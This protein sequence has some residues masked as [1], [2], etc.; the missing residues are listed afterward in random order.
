MKSK[1]LFV[2]FLTF[3]IFSC[4]N[5]D[6]AKPAEQ[7][8]LLSSVTSDGENYVIGYH[9]DKKV[10]LIEL[11]DDVAEFTYTD[12]KISSISKRNLQ[13]NE[14]LITTFEHDANGKIS[15]FTYDDLTVEVAYNGVSNSYTYTILPKTLTFELTTNGEVEKVILYDE[16]ADETFSCG[17]TFDNANKGALA[18]TNPVSI[19]L[20]LIDENSLDILLPFYQHPV[21]SAF[22]S[23]GN[24]DCENSFDEDGYIE[25]TSIFGRD[26]VFYYAEN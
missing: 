6:D 15:S 3:F 22:N 24:Y 4:K 13:T 12:G 2:G 11:R 26:L 10:K 21:T 1:F 18:G 8:K 20:F 14:Q 5:D 25:T 9:P 7:L 16:N 23:F 17:Y 19:Y